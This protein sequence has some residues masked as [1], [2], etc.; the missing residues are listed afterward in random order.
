M[1][2]LRNLGILDR[3]NSIKK[4]FNI[5]VSFALKEPLISDID[6]Q[7]E[8]AIGYYPIPIGIVDEFRRNGI[9]FPLLLATEEKTI[10]PALNSISKWIHNKNGKITSC[11]LG[12]EIIGQV[13]FLKKIFLILQKN[14][15]YLS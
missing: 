10:I 4:M 13:F 2:K 5:D 3:I 8:N 9:L 7:L 14:Y 6:Q 12:V 1:E 11:I 15:H